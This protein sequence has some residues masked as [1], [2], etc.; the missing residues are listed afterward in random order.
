MKFLIVFCIQVVASDLISINRYTNNLKNHKTF[1]QN[2]QNIPSTES[3][4]ESYL[5]DFM[6]EQ[7]EA[8]NFGKVRSLLSGLT[9]YQPVNKLKKTMS[10]RSKFSR[11]Y[12]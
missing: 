7:W 11:R 10:I 5:M 9:K 6:M 8:K 12:F 3:S 1:G 4:A 2:D